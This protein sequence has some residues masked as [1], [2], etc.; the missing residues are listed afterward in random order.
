VYRGGE[1]QEG[2]DVPE[3]AGLVVV[4][5]EHGIGDGGTVQQVQD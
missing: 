4:G 1:H 5:R 2:R 3:G